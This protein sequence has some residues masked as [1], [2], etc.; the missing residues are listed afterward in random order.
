VDGAG[1][2]EARAANEFVEDMVVRKQEAARMRILM[3]H[4]IFSM[5]TLPLCWNP[6]HI[7]SHSNV[8][9]EI[10]GTRH[11]KKKWRPIDLLA[12]GRFYFFKIK[13]SCYSQARAIGSAWN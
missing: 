11:E 1:A 13:R 3:T 2:G 8:L 9:I 4:L 10:C 5:H 6:H 12:L 7:G